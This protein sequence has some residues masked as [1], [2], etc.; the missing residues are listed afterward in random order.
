MIAKKVDGKDLTLVERLKLAAE[1]GFDGVDFD[2]AGSFT[3][4]QARD[5]RRAN[6]ASSCTTRSTT[7]TGISG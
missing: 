6:L 4:E 1:A 5:A 3:P 7:P 2:E